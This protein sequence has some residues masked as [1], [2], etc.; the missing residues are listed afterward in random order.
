M[1]VNFKNAIVF[2]G[3]SVFSN[4]L[5]GAEGPYDFYK[6]PTGR[7]TENGPNY[8]YAVHSVGGPIDEWE[9]WTQLKVYALE[10]KGDFEWDNIFSAGY[11]DECDDPELLAVL[12]DFYAVLRLA[13]KNP[14]LD[15]EGDIRNAEAYISFGKFPATSDW[16]G[17]VSIVEQKMKNTQYVFGWK[18]D[19]NGESFVSSI[20]PLKG[21]E[22]CARVM[23]LQESPV[24]IY[25]KYI[26]VADQFLKREKRR[27]MSPWHG[28]MIIDFMHAFASKKPY[29][30]DITACSSRSVIYLL[31]EVINFKLRFFGNTD[32]W[33]INPDARCNGVSYEE[34]V[35][36]YPT[37]F[38]I[39]PH[40]YKLQSAHTKSK[41][42]GGRIYG[43]KQSSIP[44]KYPA[45]LLWLKT[46][47]TDLNW[48]GEVLRARQKK[49][50]VVQLE[51]DKQDYKEDNQFLN[52]FSLL[53]SFEVARRL[54]GGDTFQSLPILL[55]I[56]YLLENFDNLDIMDDCFRLLFSGEAQY[57]PKN[58]IDERKQFVVE[59]VIP[60]QKTLTNGKLLRD[61]LRM[62]HTD[63]ENSEDEYEG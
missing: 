16:V 56:P 47:K 36:N 20:H 43:L 42:G 52:G 62:F 27:Y 8:I 31:S 53:L 14:E 7:V 1:K 9:G 41:P 61:K 18:Q 54:V 2:I 58:Q 38:K 19:N 3:L 34:Y 63:D 40:E 39:G 5:L 23:S 45:V 6:E 51:Q 13:K 46:H 25:Q 10:H 59:R 12:K 55:T 17:E 26:T 32:F 24:L 57:K 49:G 11:L 21:L 37:I 29:T 30:F 48:Y 15:F 44:E 22:K 33:T 28:L 35:D 4:N 60:Y 50:T